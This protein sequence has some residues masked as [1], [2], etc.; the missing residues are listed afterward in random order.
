MYRTGCCRN[1]EEVEL[2]LKQPG[3]CEAAGQLFYPRLQ[4]AIDVTQ[5][6]FVAHP[7]V[8]AV[9]CILDITSPSIVTH[10]NS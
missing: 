4:L 2:I 8:Q 3:G 1:A 6:E 10:W 5:K 9:S 7:H